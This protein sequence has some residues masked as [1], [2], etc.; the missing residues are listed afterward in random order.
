[1][2]VTREQIIELINQYIYANG[3]QLITGEQL[4]EI[5]NIIAN[6][7]ALEGESSS[8]ID[9]VL[10]R[11]STV[12][13]G[14]EI[15]NNHGG[16]I[17]LASE[18]LLLDALRQVIGT[19]VSDTLN[20]SMVQLGKDISTVGT[21]RTNSG[22]NAAE[23]GL[24]E[25]MTKEM[26]P[27]PISE[28]NGTVSAA[29]PIS[30]STGNLYISTEGGQR[31]YS[32]GSHTF[33]IDENTQSLVSVSNQ[34]IRSS[35]YHTQEKLSYTTHQN[36]GVNNYSLSVQAGLESLRINQNARTNTQSFSNGNTEESFQIV[37]EIKGQ[38]WM[39][40]SGVIAFIGSTGFKL[41]AG[42][43]I[44]LTQGGKLQTAGLVRLEK[45]SAVVN[46]SAVSEKSVISLTV[47]SEGAYAGNIRITKKV[48]GTSFT[49]ASKDSTD[50]CVVFWQIIELH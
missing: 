47:Q 21:I 35:V 42:R 6:S 12:S 14:K 2:R 16:R 36:I 23:K 15:I 10:E 48:A 43:K 17:K 45:G 31:P 46:T 34:G 3:R 8:G 37:S 27:P 29:E 9:A 25:N 49:I 32:I 22:E 41:K 33:F 5:L 26:F 11:G 50:N 13:D 39:D 1:M 30:F 19:E 44:E 18:E 38:R 7:F 40:Q 28:E 20:K 24:L 4:N